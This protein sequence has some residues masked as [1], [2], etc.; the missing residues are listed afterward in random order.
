MRAKAASFFQHPR[1]VAAL[2]ITMAVTIWGFPL[3]SVV[4]QIRHPFPGFSYIPDILL[5]FI[6]GYLSLI[7]LCVAIGIIARLPPTD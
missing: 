7:F 3:H 5:F 6:C 4:G 2:V 1:W